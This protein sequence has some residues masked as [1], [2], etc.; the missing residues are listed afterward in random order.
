M[1]EISNV[2]LWYA[3]YKALDN[4]SVSMAKGQTMVICGPSGSG[5]STLL[6]CTNGLESFQQGSISVDGV[7]VQDP[8]TDIYALRSRIGM[9]F[10]HFELYP[11]K[12]ILEN[13]VLAP[14]KV[15]GAPRKDAER[16]G[17][18]LLDRV[19][20]V[21]QAGKYPAELSGGQQQRV[22]IARALA[23]EPSVM[24]FDEPTSALD[25]EMIKEVLD[26]MADL[27]R[28][29]M[30]MVVVTH[31]MGFARRVADDILFMD[32][33]RIV[34]RNTAEDFFLHPSNERTRQF[35]E[36]VMDYDINVG[37]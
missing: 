30:T 29:G 13:V 17:L 26:V 28:E 8:A 10:Q 16:Q 35:L 2:S 20:V 25:P 3:A 5:K 37:G 7:G 15:K 23:M 32:Q 22:S 4:I 11:H 31:E 34:E 27:A 14:V 18:A 9:V 1:I 19:G 12:T 6:R 36:R 21:D 24:L 33:G